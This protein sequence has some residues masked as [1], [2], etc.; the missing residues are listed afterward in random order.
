[1]N[2]IKTG[3]Y[4]LSRVDVNE[5]FAFPS[6]QVAKAW[7]RA[8]GRSAN[9]MFRGAG[10]FKEGTLYF[11]PQS[12][13]FVLRFI[14]RAVKSVQQIKITAYLTNCYRFQS[15]YNMLKIAYALKLKYFLPS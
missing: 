3:A 6:E 1:M 2:L 4:R 5:H 7:L 11:T 13:R 9:M 15:Y 14:I 8:A 10:L 12:R